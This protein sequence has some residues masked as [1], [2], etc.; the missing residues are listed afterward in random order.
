[1]HV[2]NALHCNLMQTCECFDADVRPYQQSLILSDV[3]HLILGKT[4]QTLLFQIHVKNDVQCDLMQTCVCFNADVRPYQQS[5]ILSD[6]AHLIPGNTPNASIP[7]SASA[8][9]ATAG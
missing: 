2:K 7:A 5:V 3:P 8:A 1:M 4:L 9:T 6:V